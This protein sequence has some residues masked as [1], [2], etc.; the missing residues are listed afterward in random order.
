MGAIFTVSPAI[1][2]ADWSLALGDIGAVVQGPDDVAQC[3]VIIFNTPKGSDP[4][5]PTFASDLW[6]YVDR[7]I[8]RTIPAI[9]REA[10][11]AITLWEPRISLISLTP[12]AILDGSSQNGAK[13]QIDL[14]YKLKLTGAQGRVVA[15]VFGKLAKVPFGVGV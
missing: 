7:P 10:T 13:L 9:V 6:K 3:I 1:Q 15:P 14:V 2:S 8:N 12:T 5:R 11:D 4:L